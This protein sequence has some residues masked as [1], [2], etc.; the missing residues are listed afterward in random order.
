LESQKASCKQH[1]DVTVMY[2]KHA[3]CR[4]NDGHNCGIPPD[5][6][7]VSQSIVLCRHAFAI[8]DAELEESCDQSASS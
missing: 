8:N 7:H 6:S 5:A 3:F 1:S 2:N 4:V